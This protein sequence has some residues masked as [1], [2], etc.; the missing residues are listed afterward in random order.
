MVAG[1]VP[2]RYYYKAALLRKRRCAS[3]PAEP[4]ENIFCATPGAVVPRETEL[5]SILYLFFAIIGVLVVSIII[6]AISLI[7]HVKISSRIN[8]LEKDIEKKTL[9][10]DA[11][12]KDR[13][14]GHSPA[15][16]DSPLDM[17][18]K[19]FELPVSQENL[20]TA[21]VHPVEEGSIQIVRN[22]RGT[23]ET[24][25]TAI[26]SHG[27]SVHPAAITDAG[28]QPEIRR[29]PEPA[30]V[31]PLKTPSPPLPAKQPEPEPA[32]SVIPLLSRAT[33]RPEF[34]Q[35]YKSL[36]E[37]LKKSAD[38]P[39]AFDF[40]GIESLNDGELEYLEKIHSFL[41][42]QRRSLTFLNCSGNLAALLRRRPQIAPLIR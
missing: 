6:A 8:N 18:T 41:A 13:S 10:F 5:M 21:E 3:N 27:Y 11:L 25:D 9:E 34:N 14:T 31:P 24:T 2:A 15:N 20:M 4:P 1:I 17:S 7:F 33:G 28:Q 29:G 30:A 22:V 32:G 42:N 19:V 39:I 23:F 40:S 12:K 36:V 35:L 16:R 26:M 38:Q 37:T